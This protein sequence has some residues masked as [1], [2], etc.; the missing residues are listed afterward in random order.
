MYNNNDYAEEDEGIAIYLIYQIFGEAL[1]TLKDV[2]L[3]IF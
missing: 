1:F 2:H 3:D